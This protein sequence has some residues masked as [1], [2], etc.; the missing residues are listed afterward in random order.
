AAIAHLYAPLSPLARAGAP[1][2][3]TAPRNAGPAPLRAELEG[4]GDG[5]EARPPGSNRRR[6]RRMP[7]VR[8][9][10]AQALPRRSATNLVASPDFTRMRIVRLPSFCASPSAL[11]TSEGLAPFLPPTS[12][13]TSRVLT[14]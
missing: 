13:M 1:L 5:R 12:R 2:W 11:R 10:L 4:D 3:A 9:I 7:A 8:P 14:L 6:G